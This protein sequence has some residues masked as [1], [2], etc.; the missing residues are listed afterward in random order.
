MFN[1]GGWLG[2][3]F[4]GGGSLQAQ[5]GTFPA[6]TANS[7]TDNRTY[8]NGQFT[9]AYGTA[10]DPNNK[11]GEGPKLGPEASPIG[12]WS[13]LG[14]RGNDSISGYNPNSGWTPP[15]PAANPLA[16]WS[17]PTMMH[18]TNVVPPAAPPPSGVAPHAREPGSFMSATQAA[19]TQPMIGQ[20]GGGGWNSGSGAPASMQPMWLGSMNG[21]QSW[22]QASGYNANAPKPGQSGSSVNGVNWKQAPNQDADSPT[23]RQY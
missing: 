6:P 2:S 3:L 9:P 7:P 19:T 21:G 15:A 17:N 12:G 13:Q 14:G 20:W 16:Q 11:F 23:W 1:P 5:P 18:G 22:G 4:A 8:F 10:G